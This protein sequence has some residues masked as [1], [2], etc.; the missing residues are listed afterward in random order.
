MHQTDA[1]SPE[2]RPHLVPVTFFVG[3]MRVRVQV[4][5]PAAP[6]D[7][8]PDGKEDDQGGD[9]CLRPL[10]EALRQVGLE[11][12]DRQPEDDQRQGVA[13]T[14]EA[15]SSGARRRAPYRPE[16]TSAVTA[17]MWSGSVA[18][19]S[20]SSAA[21]RRTTRTEPPFGHGGDVIV[22]TEHG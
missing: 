14:P 9:R 19:R 18:W 8:Q 15:P 4:E 3:A 1:E 7:Q 20:P 5:E 21:T 22:E 2:R 10:L 13:E 17:A 12:H 16:A 6:A 11:E